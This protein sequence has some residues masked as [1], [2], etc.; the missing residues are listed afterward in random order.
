MLNAT[1][2]LTPYQM[3]YGRLPKGILSLVEDSWAGEVELPPNLSKTANGYL[4]QLK[5]DIELSA[6]YANEN[7]SIAQERFT[8]QHNLYSKMYISA[9]TQDSNEIPTSIFFILFDL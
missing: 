3:I 1:T 7:A 9:C 2:G 6:Q 8:N 5:Q 4:A